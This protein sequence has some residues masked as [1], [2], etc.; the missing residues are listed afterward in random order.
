MT[1]KM[2]TFDFLLK[3]IIYARK[4]L[5]RALLF[6]FGSYKTAQTLIAHISKLL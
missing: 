4:D 2:G 5:K 1:L 6:R 3:T